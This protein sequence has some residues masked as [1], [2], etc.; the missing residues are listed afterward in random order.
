MR[1]AA[2]LAADGAH[3]DSSWGHRGP[4]SLRPADSRSDRQDPPAPMYPAGCAIWLPPPPPYSVCSAID[5]VDLVWPFLCFPLQCSLR[6]TFLCFQLKYF[7]DKLIW[8]MTEAVPRR[9]KSI[10]LM[11]ESAFPGID[12]ESARDSS[13]FPGIDS[14]R[15]ITQNAS[16]FF[17]FKSTHDSSKKQ[18]ILSRLMI[19][20]WVIPMFGG[21]RFDMF[22][23]AFTRLLRMRNVVS[24]DRT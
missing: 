18:L 10:Q 19:R 20:L 1:W 12:S 13:G 23:T 5:P 6:M 24:S 7:L 11:S 15:L 9:L 22:A 16:R 21:E 2:V 17:D 3:C 8:L 4:S 14:D